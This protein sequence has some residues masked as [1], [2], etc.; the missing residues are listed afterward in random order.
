LALKGHLLRVENLIFEWNGLKGAE[1]EK[2]NWI[3]GERIWF[4]F[5]C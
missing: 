3:H 2:K 4:Q 1:N 5:D